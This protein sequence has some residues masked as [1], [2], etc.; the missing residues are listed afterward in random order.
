MI[1]DYASEKDT[2]RTPVQ[3][4]HTYA[5]RYGRQELYDGVTTVRVLG[6]K[7]GIDFGYK[8]A[9]DRELLPGPRIIPSGP[10]LATSM[11]HGDIIS[12][13]VNG[14]IEARAAVRDNIGNGA[15]VIKMFIS[16]GR[17]LGVP[18]HLTTS[19]FTPEEIGAAIDEAHKFETRV[20]AHLN[21]G[22]AI[23]YAL[24]AGLDSIEHGM[25]FTDQEM[26]LVARSGTWV[27]LTLGWHFT[28]S[29][30]ANLGDQTSAVESY[31]RRLYASGARLA[32][33]NDCCHADHGMARQVR[34]LTQFGVPPMEALTIATQGSAAACGIDDQRGTLRVGLDADLVVLR[35]NPLDDIDALWA[36][37]T[38]VK[39]G[40][41][42]AVG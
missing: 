4:L 3:R 11:S 6:E 14:P 35:G 29:Y 10:A 31:V 27:V 8:D 22:P 28:P 36:I 38:V 18:Y 2:T 15:E 16:G 1:P 34:W 40:R 5:V 9:F 26:E 13:V 30:V 42:Y 12:T 19:F 24:D 37:D 20:T 25:E 32:L 7:D 17:T 21:G 23:G 39:G 33:G 41:A